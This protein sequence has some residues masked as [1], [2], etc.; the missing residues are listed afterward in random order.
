[1]SAAAP[2]LTLENADF[3][4]GGQAVVCGVSGAFRAGTMTAV[5]GPN[6]VGKST[7]MKGLAGALAP[8]AG[9]VRR[10][11]DGR[12]RVAW[13][14]QRADL[15]LAFPLDVHDLVAMGAWRRTGAWRGLGAAE[16][17]RIDAAMVRTGIAALARRRL[18]TLSGGQLQ[19]ALFARLLV[20]DADLLL[21]DEPFAAVDTETVHQLCRLLGELNREGRTVIAVLHDREVVRA[22][23]GDTLA[24][25]RADGAGRV[26]AW[27]PTPAAL[28]G[29]AP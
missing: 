3:G 20:Q 22:Y 12:A 19:R 24:L 25:A 5:V 9:A 13:L 16:Q 28:D 7:L 27:A 29:E 18:D 4:W 15:D 6:G 8:L 2:L 21:L 11:D 17:A 10:H 14:P 1:M 23:F 26:Q